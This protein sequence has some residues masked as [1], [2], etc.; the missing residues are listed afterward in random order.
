V[1]KQ[2]RKAVEISGG[3]GNS[4]TIR[5]CYERTKV[6]EK[7]SKDWTERRPGVRWAGGRRNGLNGGNNACGRMIRGENGWILE[8]ETRG[9]KLRICDLLDSQG[10]IAWK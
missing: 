2:N 1:K 9:Q 3:G 8:G 5:R 6:E 7:I 10:E 4:L